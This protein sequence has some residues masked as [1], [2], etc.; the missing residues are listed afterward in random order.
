MDYA[1]AEFY[2]GA[3]IPPEYNLSHGNADCGVLLLWTR[4]R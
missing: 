2:Q 3:D 4:D 1:A